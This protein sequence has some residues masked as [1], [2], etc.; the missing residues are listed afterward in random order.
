MP[1]AAKL[2]AGI[3]F[4][5][6][7]FISAH[8]YIPVLPEGSQVNVFPQYNAALGFLVGWLI[9]GRGVGNGIMAAFWTGMMTS[10]WFYLWA[11]LL[12]SLRDM[13]EKSTKLYY[14]QPTQAVLAVFENI[15]DYGVLGLYAPFIITLLAGGAVAGILTELG[16]RRWN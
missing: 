15:M 6:V 14:K 11:L 12:W 2:I 8:A 7:A 5:L 13:L 4:A 9:L 16:N 3:L 1:T 10:V